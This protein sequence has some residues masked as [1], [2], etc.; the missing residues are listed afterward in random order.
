MFEQ[1]KFPSRPEPEADRLPARSQPDAAYFVL[2]LIACLPYSNTLL[3]GFVYDDNLQI[4]GNP[5][6]QNFHHLRQITT[7]VWAFVG[8]AGVYAKYFRP[9]MNLGY[10]ILHKIYGNV[11]L[12]FSYC[13]FSARR[14]RDVS[15]LWRHA[16]LVIE[17]EAGLR[18]RSDFRITCNSL[19]TGGLGCGYY[20]SGGGSLSSGCLL[21]L[22]RSAGD[23]QSPMGQ[24]LPQWPASLA[25]PSFP[26]RWLRHL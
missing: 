3:N 18:R 11:A 7:D 19:R 24:I 9:V 17:P 4:L 26:K 1:R 8:A 13:Q 10:I 2:F 5:S 6:V 15:G 23:C 22:R 14:L 25:R 21:D 20:R 16:S 12:G